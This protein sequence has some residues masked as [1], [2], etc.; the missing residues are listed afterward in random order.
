MQFIAL[1]YYAKCHYDKVMKKKCIVLLILLS[2][3]LLSI[4]AEITLREDLFSSAE[5]LATFKAEEVTES[6]RAYFE[7]MRTYLLVGG[8]GSAIW[9]NFGHAAFVIERDGY[10]TIAFDYGIFTF[11]ETFIPNFIF[12]KLYYEV[13]ETY[14]L[15]RINS[16]E[17]DDRS[18][19][20]ISLDL[21]T[22]EKKALYSFLV[23]N[24]EEENR[25]YLYDY[26][27][28]NCA[29]RLRDIYSYATGGDFEAYLK[30]E[31]SDETI[32][33]SISRYLSRSTFFAAWG[34]NYLLGPAVDGT[35]SQWEMCYLPDNLIARI[36]EYQNSTRTVIYE[37]QKR[38]ETPSSWSLEFYSLI[39]ALVLSFISLLT[40]LSRIHKPGDIILGVLY[41]I[42]GI[43]SLTLTFLAF[44]TIHNVTHNNLNIA[45][46]SPLCL[47]AGVLHF[48]SLS[49]SGRKEKP[50]C[51]VN[52]VMFL[53]A[54]LTVLIRL[55]FN[56]VLI[57]SIW[58]TA[59]VALILYASE[60]LPYIIKT[61]IKR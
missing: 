19:Y 24:T 43:M 35:V 9:E 18:V 20:L 53:F 30:A 11:D 60:A 7:N 28:D 38:E 3:T 25:T 52:A 4:G 31:K 59:I 26:F 40:T 10:H 6:D 54:L 39:F 58:A 22:D 41:T 45:L 36:E 33:E 42:F 55:I 51:F 13:W 14:A 27:S 8:P 56:T 21:N 50:L 57:Q 61:Y 49:K 5:E 34:I 48:M 46:I 15:Y 1:L 29:T 37:T 12:G 44:F 16:L 23:Y 2:L 47:V 17:E 32:R